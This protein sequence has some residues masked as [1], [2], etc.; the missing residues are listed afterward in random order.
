MPGNGNWPCQRCCSG[1]K[2][3]PSV[4]PRVDLGPRRRGWPEPAFALAVGVGVVLARRSGTCAR[5][6]AA[7]ASMSSVGTSPSISTQ[8]SSCHAA[9]SSS[10][11]QPISAV[12]RAQDSDEQLVEPCPDAR[13]QHVGVGY[14]G[15]VGDDADAARVAVR[16]QRDVHRRARRAAR[17]RRAGRR[18]RRPRT[19]APARRA[20]WS[21]RSRST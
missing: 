14:R 3:G 10:R 19:P 4:G 1:R 12:H 13:E 8:P 17:T 20:R 18:A 7:A 11:S 16:D 21:R 6:S 2:P 5:R 15:R 9:T